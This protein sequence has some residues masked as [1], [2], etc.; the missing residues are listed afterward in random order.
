MSGGTMIYLG[1]VCALN[2]GQ[3][4]NKELDVTSLGIKPEIAIFQHT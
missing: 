2:I 1:T 4:I 3:R